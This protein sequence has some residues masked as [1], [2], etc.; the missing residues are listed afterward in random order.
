M[1]LSKEHGFY[2]IEDCAQA[3]GAKYKGKSVGSIG[4]VGAWSFCQDKI[5]TT[6]GEGGMVT[7]NSKELWSA[8]WSYK[9]HGKALMQFITANTRQGSGGYT[10]AL[11]W[12]LV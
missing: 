2:V 9:D 1:A 4:H 7:T 5:M 12:P 6:G 10:R 8:M 3:H 11:V